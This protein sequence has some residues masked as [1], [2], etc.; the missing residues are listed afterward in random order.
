MMSEEQA[1]GANLERILGQVLFLGVVVSTAL[2]ALGLALWIA[3]PSYRA[4]NVSLQ[5]GLV[6][7]MVTPALR[8]LVS[9]V[10]YIRERDWVFAGLTSVVLIVLLGSLVVAVLK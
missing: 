1:S 5:A 8:V 7:L 6:V 9:C 3:V 4:A 10:E 2:L